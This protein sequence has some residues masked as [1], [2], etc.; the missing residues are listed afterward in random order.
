MDALEQALQDARTK[1]AKDGG[2]DEITMCHTVI[3]DLLIALGWNESQ[4]KWQH[5]I[6][7][8]EKAYKADFVLFTNSQDYPSLIIEVKKLGSQLQDPRTMMQVETYAKL[9]QV[10]VAIITDGNVWRFY[11]LQKHQYLK[12]CLALE[13]SLEK[14]SSAEFLQKVLSWD[15]WRTAKA[16]GQ[17]DKSRVRVLLDEAWPGL[18]EEPT[19]KQLIIGYLRDRAKKCDGTLLEDVDALAFL[20]EKF[21]AEP[22]PVQRVK[23]D[24]KR[25]PGKRK[26]NGKREPMP[27][28]G[29]LYL[30]GEPDFPYKNR[31]KCMRT[32]FKWVYG[33]KPD[34]LV[35]IVGK[36]YVKRECWDKADK[37]QIGEYWVNSVISDS[38]A[39]RIVGKCA[40][41]L[42][43][44]IAYLSASG[45]RVTHTPS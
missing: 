9:K 35:N 23:G 33:R 40:K 32:L 27:K 25:D 30:P 37:D 26:R 38:E 20:K 18:L 44:D 14:E 41:A 22:V 6:P 45:D 7:A 5:V 24:N 34:S 36:T 2:M 10:E 16:K 19:I 31:A 11:L 15:A 17:L 1:L 13:V 29:T 4:W 8:H 21:G 39:A 12:D 28:E 3:K 43:E 42:D